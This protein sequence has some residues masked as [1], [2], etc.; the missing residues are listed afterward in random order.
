M[1]EK[2]SPTRLA[3]YIVAGEAIFG[4]VGEVDGG[5]SGCFVG[6]VCQ[7]VFLFLGNVDDDGLAPEERSG[8]GSDNVEGKITYSG[9]KR[10]T[11]L[12]TT[13]Y[14]TKSWRSCSLGPQPS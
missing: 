12:T 9:E 6:V 11:S 4:N 7:A 13:S 1:R 14:S 10:L 8:F 3:T 2:L 5:G